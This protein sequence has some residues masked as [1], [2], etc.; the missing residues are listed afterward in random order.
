[1]TDTGNKYSDAQLLPLI[2]EAVTRETAALSQVK[3][4]LEVEKANLEVEKAALT[5]ELSQAKAKLDVLEVE[6]AE[7]LKAAE[8]ATQDLEDFKTAETKAAQAA[9]KKMDR[10]QCVKASRDNFPEGFFTEERAERWAA[11]D[12]AGFAAY[13]QDLKEAAVSVGVTA[14]LPGNESAQELARETAA[15]Q[16]GQSPTAAKPEGHSTLRNLLNVRAGRGIA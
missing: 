5:A 10:T 7:A 12:D 14:V 9:A 11:M 4:T 2:E 15:F 3:A 16:G 8:K 6:K 1:M 13:L